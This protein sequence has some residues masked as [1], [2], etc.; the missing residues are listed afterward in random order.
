MMPAPAGVEGTGAGDGSCRSAR[1]SWPPISCPMSETS[2]REL[3]VKWRPRGSRGSPPGSE[4]ITTLSSD[5]SVNVPAPAQ[6][7]TS[8]QDQ[9]SLARAGAIRAGAQAAG[10]NYLPAAFIG[11]PH[12]ACQHQAGSEIPY[13]G[14]QWRKR[15]HFGGVQRRRC[16]AWREVTP[17]V[18]QQGRVR[19]KLRISENTPGRCWK[20]ENGETRWPSISRR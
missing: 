3:G 1:W 12:A 20:R 5:V 13:R 4:Q 18:L 14:F 16:W 7:L 2:L 11:L 6:G 10:R 19:L 9:R 15:R 8:R 17:T